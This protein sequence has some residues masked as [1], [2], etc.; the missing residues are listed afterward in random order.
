MRKIIITIPLFFFF[1]PMVLKSQN[2]SIEINR[3][4]DT[5]IEIR[6]LRYKLD[7]SYST[8]EFSFHQP[9]KPGAPPRYPDG[10]Y[11]K[12]QFVPQTIKIK[13]GTVVIK[14]RQNKPLDIY[15]YLDSVVIQHDEYFING[16]L[17]SQEFDYKSE[18]LHIDKY[19]YGNGKLYAITYQ[20]KGVE[21]T[22][23]YDT[24]GKL[25]NIIK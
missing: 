25:I 5:Y 18:S 10:I 1:I 16:G 23:K 21:E 19:F 24:D 20:R 7:T 9:A 22:F 11:V 14:D 8:P 4:S 6:S 3:I 12:R 13:N 15:F 17:C 2:D